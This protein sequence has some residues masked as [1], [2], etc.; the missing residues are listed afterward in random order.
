[1]TY[2]KFIESLDE[3]D[4]FTTSLIE[5]LVK[6][7][8]PPLLLGLHIYPIPTPNRSLLTDMPDK[9]LHLDGSFVTVHLR[10]Y[11]P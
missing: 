11:T 4:S 5:I 10:A 3:G 1:M 7:C 2:E 8:D 6:V 9:I